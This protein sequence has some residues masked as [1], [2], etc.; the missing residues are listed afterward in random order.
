MRQDLVELLANAKLSLDSQPNPTLPRAAL[1]MMIDSEP[2]PQMKQ[3]TGEAP[4]PPEKTTEDEAGKNTTTRTRSKRKLDKTLPDQSS[5]ETN[6][7]RRT[8]VNV[9]NDADTSAGHQTRTLQLSATGPVIARS[10]GDIREE[11]KRNV[12]SVIVE[13]TSSS[14]KNTR[15]ETAYASNASRTDV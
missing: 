14:R 15:R 9:A 2:P 4:P 5:S 13:R 7:R 11:Y 6:R 10:V 3:N 12:R 8:S 1:N